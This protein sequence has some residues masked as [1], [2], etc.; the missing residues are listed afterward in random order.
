VTGISSLALRFLWLG[1]CHF[2]IRLLSNSSK[3]F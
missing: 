3:T 2:R 1:H